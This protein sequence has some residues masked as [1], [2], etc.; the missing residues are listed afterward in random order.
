MRQLYR[1][2]EY[3]SFASDSPLAEID[4]DESFGDYLK[5]HGVPEKLK[6]TLRGPLEMILGDPAPA[7]QGTDAGLHRRNDAERRQGVHARARH[8]LPEPSTRRGLL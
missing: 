2:A 1:Q 3:L 4:D 7:G 8:R 5:R 6:V